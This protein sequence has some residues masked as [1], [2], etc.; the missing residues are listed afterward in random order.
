MTAGR[1]G[2]ARIGWVDE[3]HCHPGYRSLEDDELPQ[4]S[5][6]PVMQLGPL[7]AP[8]L[9]PVADASEVFQGNAATEPLRLCHHPFGDSVVCVPLVSP[10]PSGDFPELAPRRSRPPLLQALAAVGVDPLFFFQRLSA[11]GLLLA[12]RE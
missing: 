2:A 11:V 12:V 5:E 8:G 10:L 6:R 3:D 7:A 9:Y 1:A 4:L